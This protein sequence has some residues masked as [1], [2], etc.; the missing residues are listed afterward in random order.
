MGTQ[1]GDCRMAILPETL[2]NRSASS[3]SDP[4]A[5]PSSPACAMHEADDAYMGYAGQA[6][7]DAFLSKLFAAE[8]AAADVTRQAAQAARDRKMLDLLQEIQHDLAVSCALLSAYIAARHAAGSSQAGEIYEK[9]LATG[10]ARRR[11]IFL[12]CGQM[13]MICDLQAMLRRVRDDA[14]YADLTRTLRL[15]EMN[16]RR[17]RAALD[18]LP[19]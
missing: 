12:N 4:P 15:N 8:C 1:N 17:V 7:L 13:A 5:T 10:D 2:V 9:A 6:E 3:A 14:L 18:L 16:V 11:L 19:G